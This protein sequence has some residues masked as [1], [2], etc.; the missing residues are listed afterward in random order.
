MS[1]TGT[2]RATTN[3][4]VMTYIERYIR[5]IQSSSRM[6]RVLQDLY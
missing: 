1:T 2:V 5:N 4:I 3:Q 6:L